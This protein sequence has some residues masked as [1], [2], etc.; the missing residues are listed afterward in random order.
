[1]LPSLCALGRRA[2]I[3]QE[4]GA[5]PADE[6]VC[7][8]RATRSALLAPVNRRRAA[9]EA[10]VIDA[11]HMASSSQLSLAT[12]SSASSSRLSS[13][14]LDQRMRESV[15]TQITHTINVVEKAARFSV[16]RVSGVRE[17]V[18]TKYVIKVCL[19]VAGDKPR[20]EWQVRAHALSAA[21]EP[22]PAAP[23]VSSHAPSRNADC[24]SAVGGA[25]LLAL[26]IQPQRAGRHV[27][28]AS[29]AAPTAQAAAASGGQRCR[30]GHAGRRATGDARR[31]PE[32]DARGAGRVR[33]RLHADAH[34]PRRV[35]GHADL[36]VRTA[37]LVT[38]RVS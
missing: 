23:R 13:A 17:M 29:A 3:P 12:T 8:Q 37:Q 7:V 26:P 11:H 4:R 18:V 27:L 1:M 38:V 33:G 25:A 35:P 31:V 15:S 9:G 2:P 28:R 5:I 10:E 14:G 24:L 20:L 36:L 30:H 6:A 16:K 32:A 19:G 34:I 21:H 22:P